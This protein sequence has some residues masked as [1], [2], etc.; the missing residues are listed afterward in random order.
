M[1]VTVIIER[2]DDTEENPAR[3]VA[4]SFYL[5]QVPLSVAAIRGARFS[6]QET[7]YSKI[8]RKHEA[9][10]KQFFA[11]LST[12]KGAALYREPIERRPPT[13]VLFLRDPASS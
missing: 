13:Q 4:Q 3:R 12:I 9:L 5:A 6:N 1:N 10:E 2:L 11:D 8:R 7:K